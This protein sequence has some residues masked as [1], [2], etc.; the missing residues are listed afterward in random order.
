MILLSVYPVGFV[1][2]A[3]GFDRVP[4][5]I[6][7][8]SSPPSIVNIISLR[9]LL[10]PPFSINLCNFRRSHD[11]DVVDRYTDFAISL[12]IT[13]NVGGLEVFI[14]ID[15]IIGDVGVL[16]T[17]GGVP[18]LGNAIGDVEIPNVGVG[19]VTVLF[20][21]I[22]L[23][24]V[25]FRANGVGTLELFIMSFDA[26]AAVT[27]IEIMLSSCSGVVDISTTA[28]CLSTP[29]DVAI[30][31]EEVAGNDPGT[32]PLFRLLLGRIDESFFMVKS[33]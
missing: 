1:D 30:E 6:D 28:S 8:R 24:N 13:G 4:L 23:P 14:G 21:E 20:V 17:V 7:S 31:E 10:S 16:G 3:I 19:E 11:I 27:L 22:V 33:T 9:F 15:D 25:V 29:V 26:S 2:V 18:I 12:T 5:S 32:G